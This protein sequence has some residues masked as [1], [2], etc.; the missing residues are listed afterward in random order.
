MA[1]LEGGDSTVTINPPQP[2]NVYVPE[3]L[4]GNFKFVV[5]NP[6]RKSGVDQF[7]YSWAVNE[8]LLPSG[9]TRQG[10]GAWA[11]RLQNSYNERF[12]FE[13]PSGG[14][15]GGGGGA[16]PVY[17]AP[18]YG[19]PD[20][21]TVQEQVKA[22][23]VATLGT[24]N[25]SLIDRAVEEYM[26]KDR[27]AFDQQNEAERARFG[28]KAGGEF[29]QVDPWSAALAVIRGS[30]EYKDL[31][32]LRP[33]GVDEMEWVAGRQDTLRQIGLTAGSAENLGI[34]Q[35]RVGSTNEALVD[36]GEM[37]FNA[38]SGR[39]LRHQRESLKQSASA[40]LG[41]L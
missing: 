8:G 19:R 35:A 41:L 13:Q 23:V 15:R 36:A 5:T 14:G 12:V 1:E 18:N 39:L 4:P 2:V 32:S 9:L 24:L 33:E 21:A 16:A 40:V 3:I 17:V 38:D 27:E 22:Q 6:T 7:T 20:E 28:S 10:I 30:A 29:Q 37:Q 26:A 34:D 11:E 31:H 25:Q